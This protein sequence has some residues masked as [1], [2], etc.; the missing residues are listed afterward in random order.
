[1]M[2]HILQRQPTTSQATFDHVPA[3]IGAIALGVA[4]DHAL[5]LRATAEASLSRRNLAE[6]RALYIPP[7]PPQ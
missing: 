7:L 1:M 4:A 3:T 5:A 6:V 2:A